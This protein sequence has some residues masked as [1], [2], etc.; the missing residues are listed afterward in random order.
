[1]GRK[2]LRGPVVAGSVIALF[3]IN[4]SAQAQTAVA[5]P[6]ITIFGEKLA[7]P[8]D[9]VTTSVS[10]VT[11][12]RIRQEQLFDIH[13]VLNAVPNS[14][15]T[16]A[17][18]N[19]GGITIRGVNSEGLS[20]NQSSNSAPVIG[21]V[22][23]GVMQNAEAVRRGLRSVWDV[24][25][26]EV[27]RGPQSTLQ[28]RNATAGAVFIKTKDPTFHWE[29]MT[30]LTVGT[31]ELFSKGF[32][33]SGPIAENQLAFRIAGQHYRAE[34]DITYSDPL[35]NVLGEDR[36]GNIRGKILWEPAGVPG[37]RALFTVAHTDDRP[38]VNAVTGP[39]FFARNYGTNAYTG[40]L[41]YRKTRA[42]NYA[43]DVSYEITTNV[44]IRSITSF[45]ATD[46]DVDSAPGNPIYVRDDLR[47]GNDF[48]QDFRLEIENAGNG[49]SGVFG[50]FYGNFKTELDSNIQVDASLLGGPFGTLVNLQQFV[51]N[52]ET[53]SMAAYADLRYRLDRWVLIAGGR[54]LRDNV[55]SNAIG[56]LA[57]VGAFNNNTDETFSTFLPK[58]GVTY[59]LTPLQTVGFTY[60][61]GYRAGFSDVFPFAVPGAYKVKPEYLTSY[62]V[63]YRSRWFDERV[64]INGNVFY[65]DYKDQQVAYEPGPI[66]GW[67]IITNANRSHAYGGEL[68][69]RYLATERLTILSSVGVLFTRFDDIVVPTVG[70]FSGNEFPEAPTYTFNIGGLYKHPVGWFAGAN[71]RFVDGYYSSGDLNN[72][73]LRY[74]GS[75]TIVDARVG[76]EFK[77]STLTFFAKNLLDERYLTYIANGAGQAGVGDSRQ[78]GVTWAFRY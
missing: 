6:E 31:H 17:S 52:Y 66:P 68:E 26:V 46:T 57:L 73:P 72:T 36:F 38:G 16:R 51:G 69:A 47:K 74:V 41:D 22:V 24:E 75:A 63:S 50:L 64:G 19:N 29:A 25:Q 58:L 78:F 32:V 48:T 37:L 67:A 33:L 18:S 28:G 77:R 1:M 40:L 30:E 5:L 39:D 15:S 60:S 27:L 71:A 44:K 20:Q 54:A 23:D 34:K 4:H 62:E 70:N 35:N 42:N 9:D 49:F 21:I 53:K 59:D 65:Y 7:R 76:W 8:S 13:A 3:S 45:A 14:L 10:V 2:S 55:A 43:S 11:N 12:E 56:T 61:K